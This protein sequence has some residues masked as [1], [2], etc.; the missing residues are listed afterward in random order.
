MNYFESIK[1]KTKEAQDATIAADKEFIEGI[2]TSVKEFIDG[3]AEDGENSVCVPLS[4]DIDTLKTV[5]DY[6]VGLGFE[7]EFE[8]DT[9]AYNL[10]VE[11]K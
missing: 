3:A 1:Q 11:W 8:A 9:K 4:N 6:F 7:A 2:I 5:R 10:T